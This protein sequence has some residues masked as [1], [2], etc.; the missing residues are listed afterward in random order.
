V[1]KTVSYIEIVPIL[2]QAIKEQEARIKALEATVEELKQ[3]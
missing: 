2:L 3:K 1:L